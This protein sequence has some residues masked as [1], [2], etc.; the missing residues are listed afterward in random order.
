MLSVLPLSAA[1]LTLLALSWGAVASGA[2]ALLLTAGP[3]VLIALLA[4]ALVQVAAWR[5]LG[6]WAWLPW[7]WGWVPAAGAGAG[8]A[9][10][11]WRTG[12]TV[13]GLRAAWLEAHRAS[14]AFAAGLVVDGHPAPLDVSGYLLGTLPLAL[15]V[16]TLGVAGWDTWCRLDA[17]MEQR[18]LVAERRAAYARQQEQ[19]RQ[20][21]DTRRRVDEQRRLEVLRRQ[22]THHRPPHQE[23]QRVPVAVA[24]RGAEAGE[25][26]NGGQ[27]ADQRD[28]STRP[29]THDAQA[30]TPL[31]LPFPPTPRVTPRATPDPADLV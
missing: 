5:L 18:R 16:G 7:W 11:W 22:Q 17:R 23:P 6:E 14:V 21:E 24:Q 31:G 29:P 19:H 3:A 20:E 27:Y 26:S 4:Y 30:V 1:L 28:G 15:V 13:D 25:R 12:Q 9:V 8:V 2:G 10:W